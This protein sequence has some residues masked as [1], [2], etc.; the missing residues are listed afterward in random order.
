MQALDAATA[1]GGERP[2]G[3]DARGVDGERVPGDG[4]GQRAVV[5][6]DGVAL[7]EDR[8]GDA[9]RVPVQRHGRRVGGGGQG[10]PGGGERVGGLPW[11]RVVVAPDQ[12][13]L[14]GDRHAGE[15][16]GPARAAGGEQRHVRAEQLPDAGP[17]EV[18]GFG[19]QTLARTRRDP[20]P[21]AG[22]KTACT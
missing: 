11:P 5:V 22:S 14:G 2:G 8:H 9:R 20:P 1:R 21:S 6:A 3:R 18:F 10:D 4:A 17:D 19:A 7:K 16:H 15:V 13:A 12:V